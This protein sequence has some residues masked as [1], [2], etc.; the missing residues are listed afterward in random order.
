MHSQLLTSLPPLSSFG[1]SHRPRSALL[2]ACTREYCPQPAPS[3]LVKRQLKHG[4]PLAPFWGLATPHQDTA[5]STAILSSPGNQTPICIFCTLVFVSSASLHIPEAGHH[6]SSIHPFSWPCPVPGLT[7]GALYKE[8][9]LDQVLSIKVL[10]V[11]RCY[12][13][14]A[15]RKQVFIVS[16]QLH[17]G[18]WQCKGS[19]N[20]D[21]KKN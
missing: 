18:L 5:H 14:Q 6:D 4:S 2:R 15:L 16:H 21:R 10:L 17:Q 7:S 8:L 13:S 20:S 1:F 11:A 19:M 9:V 3:T 12:H